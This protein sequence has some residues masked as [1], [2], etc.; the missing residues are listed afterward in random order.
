M[1]KMKMMIHTGSI[2]GILLL[3]WSLT[4]CKKDELTV[5]VD[6]FIFQT[7]VP[8]P[9]VWLG[10]RVDFN[11]SSDGKKV[12]ATGST[13]T[14]GA[15]IILRIP[16]GTVTFIY[17]EIPIIDGKFGIKDSVF[18]VTATGYPRK[19][20]FALSGS[21][22]TS[23]ICNGYASATVVVDHPLGTFTNIEADRWTASR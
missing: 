9:G 1:R 2:L 4:G 22:F 3:I 12:T 10:D 16:S 21:F 15:S 20:V 11:V 13:L 5:P 19:A 23:R 8:V 7:P 6:P 17:N 14:K 18:T